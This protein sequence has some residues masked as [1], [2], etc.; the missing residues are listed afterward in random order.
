VSPLNR[1]CATAQPVIWCVVCS[2]FVCLCL[3]TFFLWAI[4]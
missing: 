4:H 2:L 3:F 1:A